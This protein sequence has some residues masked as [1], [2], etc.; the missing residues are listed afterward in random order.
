MAIAKTKQPENIDH[1]T[2]H[3]STRQR[4]KL[5]PYPMTIMFDAALKKDQLKQDLIEKKKYKNLPVL[6]KRLFMLQIS[7][8]WPRRTEYIEAR[9]VRFVMA[10]KIHHGG[11]K[12]ENNRIDVDEYE[13][14]RDQLAEFNYSS[15]DC[16]SVLETIKHIK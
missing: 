10:R 7:Q 11:D 9:V 5:R 2:T 14:V 16:D 8:K 6:N 1:M 4:G 15:V 13:N 3:M 12:E